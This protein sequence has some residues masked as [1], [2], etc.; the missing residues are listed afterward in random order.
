[1]VRVRFHT[2]A[3][4]PRP[5]FWPIPHPYWV[6]GQDTMGSF[7]VAYAES[8][9]QVAQLWPEATNLEVADATAYTF[10]SRFPCPDWF[11]LPAQEG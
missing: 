4:D 1:M 8:I 10:T 2:T 7:L 5:M 11:T 6:T 9:E 3:D